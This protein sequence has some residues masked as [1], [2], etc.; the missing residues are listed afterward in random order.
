MYNRI[1]I[2]TDGSSGMSRVYEHARSVATEGTEIHVLYVVNTA[3]FANMPMETSWEGVAGMLHD[4]GEAALRTAEEE[5]DGLR[6]ETAILEGQP[7][8][9]IVTYAA[10][11]GCDLILMGTNGRGGLNRL[12]LGSVA[13]RVVRTSPVPVLTVR[14]NAA[15]D[16]AAS[17]PSSVSADTP[18]AEI[19][20]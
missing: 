2:P 15:A 12:L 3:S 17:D 5:L 11:N 6:V 4:E 13:E 16:A 20:E 10:E 14:L 1:L 18:N 7:N 9:E 19:V 8:R